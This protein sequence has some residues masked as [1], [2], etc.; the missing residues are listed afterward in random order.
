MKNVF[1]G[2]AIGA[3]LVACIY[4]GYLLHLILHT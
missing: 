3:M 4:C 2:V 1:W